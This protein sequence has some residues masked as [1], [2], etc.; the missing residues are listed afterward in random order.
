MQITAVLERLARKS[1]ERWCEHQAHWT[2]L[3]SASTRL[4]L[5]ALMHLVHGMLC[6]TLASSA[7]WH[8]PPGSLSHAAEMLQNA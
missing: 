8:V 1:S 5:T 2:V 7:S 4:S 3:T 6:C